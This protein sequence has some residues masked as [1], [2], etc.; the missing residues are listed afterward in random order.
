[1][2]SMSRKKR[3]RKASSPKQPA[4]PPAADRGP[5]FISEQD[6]VTDK[7]AVPLGTWADKPTEVHEA[8]KRPRRLLADE[9]DGGATQIDLQLPSEKPSGG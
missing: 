3:T 6:E 2:D 9:D 5:L 7:H 8:P 4:P 1:M